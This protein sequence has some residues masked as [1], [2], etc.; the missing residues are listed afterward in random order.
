[1][2]LEN[3]VD[4]VILEM[5]EDVGRVVKQLVERGLHVESVRTR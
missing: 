3:G 1:M 5:K 2:Y 4:G